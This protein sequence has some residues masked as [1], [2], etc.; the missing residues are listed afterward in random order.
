MDDS[1]VMKS[2]SSALSLSFNTHARTHVLAEYFKTSVFFVEFFLPFFLLNS[3]E[4]A[5]ERERVILGSK[6]NTYMVM[7]SRART[8]YNNDNVWL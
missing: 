1:V 8:C 5:R 6:G 7:N 3:R 2:S 4:R